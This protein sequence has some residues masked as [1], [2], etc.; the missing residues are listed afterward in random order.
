[1]FSE[2]GGKTLMD[3]FNG[4]HLFSLGMPADFER[5]NGKVQFGACN[6]HG[7]QIYH[8]G[9]RIHTRAADSIGDRMR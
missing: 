9:V 6:N 4:F 1:M 5:F 2:K 7:L 8:R 3:E